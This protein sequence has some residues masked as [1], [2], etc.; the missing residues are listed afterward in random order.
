ALDGE[1]RPASDAVEDAFH[2]NGRQTPQGLPDGRQGR[3]AETSD[4]DIVET[5][6]DDIAGNGEP[7]FL[8]HLHG[9]QGHVVVGADDRVELYAPRD[10]LTHG[11]DAAGYGE[12]TTGRESRVQL[13]ATD[14]Q[15]FLHGLESL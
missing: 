3:I 12:I 6:D 4:R 14:Q 8:Q 9:A 13:E 1:R 5:S 15:S 2:R 10:D 7:M 11:R